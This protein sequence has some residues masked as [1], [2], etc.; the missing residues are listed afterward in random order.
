MLLFIDTETTGLPKKRQSALLEPNI[1]PDLVSIA[2]ILTT[3]D[4]III[5]SLYTIICPDATKNPRFYTDD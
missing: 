3:N 5:T 1:W 4:G 2:W